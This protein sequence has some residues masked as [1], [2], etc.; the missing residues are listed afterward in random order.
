M[1][2]YDWL[3]NSTVLTEIA[4]RGLGVLSSRVHNI[5]LCLLKH[6]IT[7]AMFVTTPE[8]SSGQIGSCG[9]FNHAYC[10]QL[11]CRQLGT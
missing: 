2:M 6:T 3:C 11:L 8:Q 5:Q 10:A 9:F 4:W 7:A 1:C